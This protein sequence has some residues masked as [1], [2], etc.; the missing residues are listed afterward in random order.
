MNTR[1][2]LFCAMS[3]AVCLSVAMPISG[4]IY[5]VSPSGSAGN[6]GTQVLP[7]SVVKAN[8][9]LMP[10]DTAILMDGSYSS[11]IF[12]ANSGTPAAPITYR[13]ANQHQ[14]K[15][16]LSG[17][18]AVLLSGRSYIVIDGI[19]STGVHRWVK[20]ESG[21]HHLTITNCYFEDAVG[22]EACRFREAGD[23]IV[24]TNN[25]LNT[26]T[27]TNGTDCL[28]ISKGDGHYIEN[29]F[30]GECGHTSLTLLGVQRSVVRGNTLVN[31]THR[32]MEVESTRLDPYG[33]ERPS[34]HNVIEQNHFGHSSAKIHFAGV[35]NIMRR[36]ICTDTGGAPEWVTYGPN[37]EPE[38]WH[39]SHNRF[40]NNTIYNS[41]LSLQHYDGIDDWGD[42]V[43]VNNII[44]NGSVSYSLAAQV[45]DASF[46]Y[47]S[48][49]KATSPGAGF[50]LDHSTWYT[51]PV[52][53]ATQPA[54][55]AENFEAEPQFVDPAVLNFR[56]QPGS[57]C[58]DA[59]GP[60]TTTAGAGA[61]TV[62]TV[63]DS[64]FFSDGLGGLIAP[65]VIHVGDQRVT[66]VSVDYVSHQL[67]VD[68]SITWANGDPVYTDYVGAGPDLGAFESSLPVVGRYVFYNNSAWDDN[69][70]NANDLDDQAIATNKSAL[71]PGD[72]GSFLNYTS[73]SR[74]INGIMIDIHNLPEAPNVSDFEFRVGN[75]NS[76]FF[77][78]EAPAATSITLRPGAGID[79]SDRVTIIWA[80]NAIENRWLQVTYLPVMDVFYV[81]NA[82]G[83]TGNSPTDAEVTPADEIAVRNNSATLGVNPAAIAHVCDFNRDRKVGPTDA[84]IA[85]NN[86]T[87]SSS[88]LKLISV[89][90]VVLNQ[91][92]TVDAGADTAVEL[93][94]GVS[95]DATVNDDGL[96]APPTLTVAWSKL[97]GT[98]TVTFADAGAIDTTATFSDAG[99]YV[100]QL[101]A[102]DGEKSE[103]D[104]VRVEVTNTVTGLFFQDD[105]DDNDISDWT[106]LVG[107]FDTAPW[108]GEPGY[109]VRCLTRN[110]R[111]RIDL[112]DTNLSDTV[113]ISFTIRHTAGA[114]GWKHGW[115]WFV[116]DTGS[117]FGIFYALDQNSAGA[118]ELKT[119]SDDGAT[120]SNVGSYANP[121]DPNGNGSKQ[122]QLIYDR[123]AN[124]VQCIYEGTPKGVI[125]L[126]PS[127]ADFT[128]LVLHLYAQYDG[129]LG[130][131]YLDN[132]RIAS[133]P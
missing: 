42:H 8:S 41:S 102:S 4:A 62:V 14:A 133:T 35:A 114:T 59:G 96:P 124:T 49:I 39:S 54:Q 115:L 64:Y 48:F 120:L 19:S 84:I 127:Y 121:G 119:T 20:A 99:L 76:P 132:I 15:F 11:Q 125:A 112:D 13:A 104:T 66:I 85:R 78:L 109:E 87:N 24:F 131:I 71:L 72:T 110:S 65:D 73:Y 52:M 79:G 9:D 90:T 58:I 70:Q 93:S 126:D 34:K 43:H 86:G 97:I 5:Y 80:D 111:M 61:G 92:P 63:V 16:D 60:L 113:Y 1:M 25:H 18:E 10:G 23:G 74:G 7:W 91:A 40:Y 33:S 12:P 77:W 44:K 57:P 26:D 46:F 122:V 88:A 83:E 94:A 100:L 129:W 36:N 123:L 22:W 75:D 105:F 107:S 38:A 89:P 29:N 98:G 17:G 45:T 27:R 56:L 3:L 101:L 30:F 103:T 47:N 68:T 106:V 51:I 69:D 21:F 6:P 53:E 67:T 82:I 95:L 117:G 116:D 108:G 55:Y 28:S 2:S 37:D 130:Q 118:L 31:F 128:K 81:G 50:F 32:T